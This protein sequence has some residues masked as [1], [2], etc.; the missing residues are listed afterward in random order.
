MGLWV[1][2]CDCSVGG[3]DGIFVLMGTGEEIC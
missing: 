2:S 1:G 3:G